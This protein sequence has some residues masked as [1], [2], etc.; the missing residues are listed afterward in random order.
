MLQEF[1]ETAMNELLGWYG[2][3]TTKEEL[4]VLKRRC[5]SYSGSNSSGPDSPKY[6]GTIN[7]GFNFDCFP[8]N[9]FIDRIHIKILRSIILPINKIKSAIFGALFNKKIIPMDCSTFL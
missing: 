1:A 3:N 7:N 5:H 2:Y 9:L 4:K 6:S 8:I